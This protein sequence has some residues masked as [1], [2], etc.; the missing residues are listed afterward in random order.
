MRVTVYIRMTRPRPYPAPRCSA[1]HAPSVHG[2]ELATA[3]RF[4][5]DAFPV[6]FYGPRGVTPAGAWRRDM[7]P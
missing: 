1:R 2:D 7:T 5:L 6:P 3:L 4:A